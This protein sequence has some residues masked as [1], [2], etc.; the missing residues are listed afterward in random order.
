MCAYGVYSLYWCYAR[1]RARRL[2][3][4][5]PCVC[6]M[7]E[8]YECALPRKMCQCAFLR[9]T[10]TTRHHQHARCGGGWRQIF[11]G[12]SNNMYVHVDKEAFTGDFTFMIEICPSKGA[13]KWNFPAG[14]KIM[15]GQQTD[16]RD[17]REDN[18]F[19]KE[20]EEE[21]H[22]YQHIGQRKKNIF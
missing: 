13:L 4:G 14:L 22:K 16:M 15:T 10:T 18:T 8:K 17:H 2:A 11:L 12:S 9:R 1:A 21:I 6:D 20:E 19:P 3:R 7:D 5:S